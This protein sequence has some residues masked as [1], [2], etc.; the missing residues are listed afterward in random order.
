LHLYFNI[1]YISDE[2]SSSNFSAEIEREDLPDLS[3][4]TSGINIEEQEENWDLTDEDS[5]SFDPSCKTVC[6]FP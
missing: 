5:D 1:V 2:A 3:L 4:C 6:S